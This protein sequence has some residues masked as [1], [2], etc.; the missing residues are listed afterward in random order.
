[1]DIFVS[2]K[3]QLPEYVL[4]F[5]HECAERSYIQQYKAILSINHKNM[6]PITSIEYFVVSGQRIESLLVYIPDKSII[7]IFIYPNGK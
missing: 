6:K 3:Q 7:N 2:M 5:M 1:M 4:L